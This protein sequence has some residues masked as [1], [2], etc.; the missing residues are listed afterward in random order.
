MAEVPQL[1]EA[2]DNET[3]IKELLDVAR[4]LEARIRRFLEEER[5]REL[6]GSP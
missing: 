3:R 2:Y 4:R 6:P 1:K 5:E